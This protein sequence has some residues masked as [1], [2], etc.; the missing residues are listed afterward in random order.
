MRKK[1]NSVGPLQTGA[2]DPYNSVGIQRPQLLSSHQTRNFKGGRS[3]RGRP[4]IQQGGVVRSGELAPRMEADHK[5]HEVVWM[6]M[7]GG[8]IQLMKIQPLETPLPPISHPNPLPHKVV[9]VQPYQQSIEAAV[10]K[11]QFS[12][13]DPQQSLICPNK[14]LDTYFKV[15]P[16]APSLNLC[17]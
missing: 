16:K 6:D 1:R 9:H 2:T 12:S 8:R 17:S 14:Q 11:E 10:V 4:F 15:C 7:G 13:Q 3:Q 5:Q